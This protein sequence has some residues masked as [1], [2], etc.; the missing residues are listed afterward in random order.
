M[1]VF[2]DKN[3]FIARKKRFL[4][5]RSPSQ[6]CRCTNLVFEMRMIAPSPLSHH[7]KQS[8]PL[9]LRTKQ[10]KAW[11]SPLFTTRLARRYIPRNDIIESYPHRRKKRQFFISTHT[12]PSLLQ[13]KRVIRVTLLSFLFSFKLIYTFYLSLYIPLIG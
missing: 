9:S 4:P 8:P 1:Q 11:Q 13:Q 5:S 7:C 6:R 2:F 10:S 12:C 3:P